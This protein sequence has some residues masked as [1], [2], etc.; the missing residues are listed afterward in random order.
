MKLKHLALL[1]VLSSC[2][3][4]IKNF[5]EYQKQ[6]LSKSKFM[7]N[8]ENL[9]GKTQ[10]IVVFALEQNNNEIATQSGLGDSL[11]NN[12]ENL[13]SKNRLGE[14]VDRKAAEKLQ[15]EIA[16]AEMKKT[17]SYKGPIVADYAI[18]GSISNAG[19][20]S[21]YSSGSTFYNPQSG[22]MVSVPPKYTYSA[23]VAGN[24]KIYELPALSVVESIE[25]SAKKSRSEATQQDGGVSLGGLQIGGKKVEGAKRDDSLVRKAAEDAISDIEVDVKNFFAKK[26]YILEKRI[27]DNKSIFKISLGSADGIKQDDKFEVIGQYESENSITNEVEVERR[28]IATGSVSD[29]I[30]PKTSWVVIGDAKKAEVLRLGDAVKMKYKKSQFAGATKFATSMLEQ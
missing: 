23:D 4:T 16:L 30:D 8:K 25:F 13:L 17:G 24:I 22:Q 19:F 20:T 5:D 2:S 26:G 1:L 28:I 18:S 10:K 27:L 21:K 7:P 3:T 14:I 12:V 11:A 15:K 29:L 6:F 9:D